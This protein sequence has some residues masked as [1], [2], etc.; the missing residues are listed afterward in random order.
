[1]LVDVQRRVGGGEDLGP[2]RTNKLSS[3]DLAERGGRRDALVDVVDPDSL[4]DLSLDDVTDAR[5][6]HDLCERGSS[7][8]R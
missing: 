1:M 7:V 6:G 5:L 2:D 4:E 8:S 3:A